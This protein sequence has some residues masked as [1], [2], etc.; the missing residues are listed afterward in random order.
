VVVRHHLRHE[1]DKIPLHRWLGQNSKQG[2]LQRQLTDIQIRMRLRVSGSRQ[3]IREQYMPMLASRIVLPLAKD[4]SV[5]ESFR[6]CPTPT[7]S[8]HLRLLGGLF[9]FLL[10]Q[11]RRRACSQYEGLRFYENTTLCLS[12]IP[13]RLLRRVASCDPCDPDSVLI[14][15]RRRPSNPP[16]KQW[17]STS[18]VKTTGT[19]SWSS[20]W[21]R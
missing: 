21:T 20:G 17:T 14:P 5:S 4:G 1:T 19:R 7:Y 15:H 16:S 2:K 12:S 8:L 13:D 6:H 9:R 10:D 18:S 11:S 3:E